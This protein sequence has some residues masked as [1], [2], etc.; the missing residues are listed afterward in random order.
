M[1]SD[2]VARDLIVTGEPFIGSHG[3][4]AQETNITTGVTVNAKRGTITTQDPALAAAAEAEF[5]VT[6]STVHPNN[7][8]VVSVKSGPG[9][10]E[11]VVAFVTAIAEGSFNILLTNLAT[12]NQADGAMEINFVVI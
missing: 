1:A 12:A 6:N 2:V 8:V 3:T 5:V 9:D 7:A 4:V 11:H 10:D